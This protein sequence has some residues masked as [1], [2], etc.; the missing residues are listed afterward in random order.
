[1]DE[2]NR[3]ADAILT[4]PSR[5]QM[6]DR[7]SQFVPHMNVE[8]TFERG[9]LTKATQIRENLKLPDMRAM[10][11]ELLSYCIASHWGRHEWPPK[12]KS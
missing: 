10:F 11:C 9:R 2:F 8:Q 12:P 3:M 1:M 7:L 6:W 4:T 5:R